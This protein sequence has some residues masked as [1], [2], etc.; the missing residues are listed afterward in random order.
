MTCKH[1]IL[2]HCKKQDFILAD[3]T[4]IC[5]GVL[6]Q[7]QVGVLEEQ[8]SYQLLNVTVRSFN[9][10]KYISL[11]EHSEIQH[12]DNIGNTA[13]ESIFMGSGSLKI[14][15]ADL[16]TIISND[17]YASCRNCNAKVTGSNSILVICGKCS[18]KMKMAKCPKKT[19]ARVI[20]EDD[21]N[22]EY[23]VTIFNDILNQILAYAVP[24]ASSINLEDQLLSA[25]VLVY[26]INSKDTVTS[27]SQVA[28]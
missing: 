26:T 8:Y 22:K 15:T 9:G 3:A 11:G 10:A 28:S 20:L 2:R 23:K 13:D 19:V 1:L 5:R 21:K 17:S 6:W 12:I 7:Q 18:A 16:V 14:I 4:N 25:P 24:H 27:V